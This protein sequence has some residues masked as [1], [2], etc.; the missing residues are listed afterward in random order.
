M[1]EHLQA[2]VNLLRSRREGHEKQIAF[3]REQIES[4][5]Y[6][7]MLSY[8]DEIIRH[9]ACLEELTRSITELEDL[10]AME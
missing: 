6:H 3:W 1:R 5:S 4:D 9:G 7:A 2:Y 10:L 8:R